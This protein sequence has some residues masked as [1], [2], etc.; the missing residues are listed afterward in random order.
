MNKTPYNLDET[1]AFARNE[2]AGRNA[3]AM[4]ANS[5]C[6][7]DLDKKRFTV[8]LLGDKYLVTFPDGLVTFYNTHIEAPIVISILVLHYLK[9]A[10]GA[11]LSHS[12]ISFKNLQGGAIYAEPFYKRAVIPFIRNFSGRL[13]DFERAAIKLGGGKTNYG[14]LSFIIPTFPR[15]P[16]LYILWLGDEELPPNGTVLFDQ[17]ANAYMQT[18]D[19]AMLAGITVGALVKI[20]N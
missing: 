2:F 15:V 11:N 19:Y 4:A 9:R 14:D 18:E 20:L 16:L 5:G 8:P 6:L 1:L 7:Y 12:W 13:K 10:T 3:L 17:A